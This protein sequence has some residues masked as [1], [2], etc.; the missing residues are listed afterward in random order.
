MTISNAYF[1]PSRR[2]QDSLVRATEHIQEMIDAI[3]A[4]E[5]KG[6]T[7]KDF[8]VAGGGGELDQGA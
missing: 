1:L 4:L 8:A 3:R 2:V 5:A 7:W 6:Y